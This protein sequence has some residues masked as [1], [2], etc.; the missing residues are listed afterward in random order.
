MHRSIILVL[1]SALVAIPL[2]ASIAGADHHE[3]KK[4]PAGEHKDH[5]KHE[6]HEMPKKPKGE[7]MAGHEGHDGHGD[8]GKK[9]KADAPKE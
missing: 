3:M 8:Y 1:L 4:P 6:G 9:P 2:S 5:G 7:D